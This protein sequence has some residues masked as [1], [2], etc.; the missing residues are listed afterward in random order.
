MIEELI[1]HKIPV[2]WPEDALFKPPVRFAEPPTGPGHKRRVRRPGE[3]SPAQPPK[4][5]EGARKKPRHRR[6]KKRPED[7][8]PMPTA[9]IE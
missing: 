6:R 9:V 4:T 2:E 5:T 3:P 8:T 7:G 1:G